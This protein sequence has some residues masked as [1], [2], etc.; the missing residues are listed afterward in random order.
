VL[1]D[2]LIGLPL[3]TKV[4]VSETMLDC[5]S[6][7]S[8]TSPQAWRDGLRGL[9]LPGIYFNRGSTRCD[10]PRFRCQEK[11][12]AST[13]G[14]SVSAV[15]RLQIGGTHILENE[16]ADPKDLLMR[17]AELSKQADDEA[18]L[19]VRERLRNMAALYNHL[20]E[21]EQELANHPA[22]IG[23]VGDLFSHD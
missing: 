5:G 14:V 23:A 10:I 22:S 21:S 12:V 19:D 7:A 13:D 9:M 2:Q 16:M 4:V 11:A 15:T 6:V 18:D 8:R 1:F 17:A 20:A 3:P